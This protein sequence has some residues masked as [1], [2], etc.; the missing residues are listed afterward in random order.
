MNNKTEHT[1]T[2]WKIVADPLNK[3]KHPCHDA[4][5]IMTEDAE[6][7]YGY[8]PRSWGLESGSIICEMR[9]HIEAPHANAEFIVRACNSHEELVAALD[10]TSKSLASLLM[11]FGEQLPVAVRNR[12]FDELEAAAKSLAKAKHS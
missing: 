10:S 1:K 9:D 8:D 7:E 3:G 5:W 4:R 11:Q 12:V 6:I 2:P